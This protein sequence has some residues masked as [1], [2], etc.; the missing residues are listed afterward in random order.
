MPL[1]GVDKLIEEKIKAKK[2]M[3]PDVMDSDTI[4]AR[5]ELSEQI[6]SLNELKQMALSYGFDISQP[7]NNIK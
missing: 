7:A 1:Y 4:R 6:R 3:I 5:E 2:K